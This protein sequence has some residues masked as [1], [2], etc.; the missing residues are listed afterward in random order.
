MSMNVVDAMCAVQHYAGQ[1]FFRFRIVNQCF[2]SKE[3]KKTWFHVSLLKL[4]VYHVSGGSFI[5][6]RKCQKS[7]DQEPRVWQRSLVSLGRVDKVHTSTVEIETCFLITLHLLI[8]L[9]GVAR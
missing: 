2:P 7:F 4:C 1:W 9:T 5:T 8:K 6:V 3:N